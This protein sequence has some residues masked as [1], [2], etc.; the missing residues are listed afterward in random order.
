M[1]QLIIKAGSHMRMRLSNNKKKCYKSW[2]DEECQRAKRNLSNALKRY[3]WKD[4]P[5]K[6]RECCKLRKVYKKLKESKINVWKEKRKMEV[7]G[8]IAENNSQSLYKL[9]RKFKGRDF[10]P[11]NISAEVWKDH[12]RKVLGGDNMIQTRVLLPQTRYIPELDSPFTADELAFALRS[13][14][15]N[16]ASGIDGI[17]AEMYKAAGQ[18]NDIFYVWLQSFNKIKIITYRRHVSLAG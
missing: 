1:Q 5:D 10:G 17:P 11:N 9:L 16:K 13:L 4:T 3:K 12:F 18:N 7:L 15:N 8:I 6:L 2:Y 14:K